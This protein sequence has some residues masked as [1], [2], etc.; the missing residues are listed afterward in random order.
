MALTPIDQIAEHGQ[1][2]L[3]QPT[4]GGRALASAAVQYQLGYGLKQPLTAVEWPPNLTS[5][6][7]PFHCE[8]DGKSTVYSTR[9]WRA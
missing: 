2:L 9:P 6:T 5:I 7:F 3:L 4:R 1:A 8:R